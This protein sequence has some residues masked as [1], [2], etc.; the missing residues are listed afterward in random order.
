METIIKIKQI[1]S[2]DYSCYRKTFSDKLVLSRSSCGTRLNLFDETPSKVFPVLI[3][4]TL[5]LAKRK[6]DETSH[7]RT[8]WRTMLEREC[9]ARASSDKNDAKNDGDKHEKRGDRKCALIPKTICEKRR[10][11]T[12]FL[13]ILDFYFYPKKGRQTDS[14]KK[15]ALVMLRLDKTNS[16][17][18]THKPVTSRIKREKLPAGTTKQNAVRVCVDKLVT[19]ELGKN[20]TKLVMHKLGRGVDMNKLVT[21]RP[22]TD[23]PTIT[24]T[25]SQCRQIKTN[26]TYVR[27]VYRIYI[28]RMNKRIRKLEFKVVC[29]NLFQDYVGYNYLLIMVIIST[30]AI[31]A[32][33]DAIK[34][35]KSPRF[36]DISRLS[37]AER[38]K[39]RRPRE[40]RQTL[41]IYSNTKTARFS[42]Q[43][44]EGSY[45]HNYANVVISTLDVFAVIT[46]I[47]V[48]QPT[49]FPKLSRFSKAGQNTKGKPRVSR[50][51]QKNDNS[52]KSTHQESQKPEANYTTNY[53]N[54]EIS[55]RDVFAVITL[56]RNNLD[57][58][59]SVT[60]TAA[61]AENESDVT[62]RLGEIK[63][64]ANVTA[65]Q[66]TRPYGISRYRNREN[67]AR[68]NAD[69]KAER[70]DNRLVFKPVGQYR[71][72]DKQVI[73]HAKQDKNE[74]YYSRSK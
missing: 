10:S 69:K 59:V 64:E 24:G 40:P 9:H 6:G 1:R 31:L 12:K 62:P 11:K 28:K 37:K 74:N 2:I 56:S 20:T 63:L 34:H 16:L 26:S 73:R 53:D 5:K 23:K 27:M 48:I 38:S 32:V 68:T 46:A 54:V 18:E 3:Y 47:K 21:H 65:R 43:K 25:A 60:L 42:S 22:T 19:H 41:E 7:A 49:G 45:I 35:I 13:K 17:H 39:A 58:V 70:G 55:T 29:K 71:K 15:P 33:I 50:P 52:A 8:S 14:R 72:L 67:D 51:T 61:E 66:H 30:R 4:V 44:S 36:S 57:A